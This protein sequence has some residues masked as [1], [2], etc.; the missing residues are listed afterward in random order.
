MAPPSKRRSGYSRRAQYST[1]FG[2]I[3]GVAG[4]LVGAAFLLVSFLEPG[5]FSWA[6]NAAATAAE[7]AGGASA[8]GRSAGKSVIDVVEGYI[9]AGSE[10]ARLRRELAESRTRL[11]EA[12][13]AHEEN[14]RLKAL[15]GLAR[16]DPA[17]VALTRLTSSS[18]SSSRRFA[19][20]GAGSADG[21]E[22]GMPVTSPLG[23]IGRVLEAGPSTSRVLL[24]TDT[25]SLVPVRRSGDGV[26]AFAQG[27]GDGTIQIRLINLGI[28]PLKKGDVFVTSGSGGLYRP[29]TVMAVATEVTS[30]GAIARVLSDP[31]ATEFVAVEDVWGPV[32]QP[33]PPPSEEED[34]D[35]E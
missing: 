10:N 15:L 29:G 8:R 4:V 13:A 25:E 9:L 20:L 3:A 27:R 23:L 31:A 18:A 2:Y 19:T 1:F 16:R 33:G 28:N 7:P 26:P 30:D 32:P 6:R 17:P 22:A 34:Q 14:E 5:A 35:G 11:V 12:E 24:V 21:V